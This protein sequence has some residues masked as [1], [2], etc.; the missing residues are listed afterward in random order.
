MVL[1]REEWGVGGMR[2]GDGA[3]GPAG[4]VGPTVTVSDARPLYSDL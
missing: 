4:G 3:V 1:Y 2:E